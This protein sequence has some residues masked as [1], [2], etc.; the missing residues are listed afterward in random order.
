MVRVVYH[1]IWI[2]LL[3]AALWPVQPARAEVRGELALITWVRDDDA[4]WAVIRHGAAPALLRRR[5]P[6]PGALLYDAEFS[7]DGRYL[8]YYTGG[9]SAPGGELRTDLTLHVLR[10]ADGA[11]V[12]SIPLVAPDF[13][14]NIT[15]TAQALAA[16]G[17]TFSTIM[18]LDE[19]VWAA[20]V[21][22]LRRMAWSPDARHLA[23]AGS[24]DGPTSDLYL[25]T[26][27]E[28]AITRLSDG[29]EQIDRIRWSPD[30]RWVWHSTVS[31]A[32]CQ[33]CDGHQYAAAADGSTMIQ[34]PGDDVHRFMGWL[35]DA[36]F[37]ETDQANG[38]GDFDLRVVAV[39]SGAVTTLWPG[40]HE[41]FA[42]DWDAQRLVVLGHP[43][44]NWSPDVQL[45]LIDLATGEQTARNVGSLDAGEDDPLLAALA[46][47]GMPSCLVPPLVY[48]CDEALFRS[49]APDGS[50][51]V[52][53]DGSVVDRNGQR[54]WPSV[55]ALAR[56]S[57]SWR[58][59]GRGYYVLRGDTLYYRD[60]T[61][62]AVSRL[63]RGVVQILWLGR[64]YNQ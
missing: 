62:G 31:Y 3:I 26:P 41:R 28:D 21:G 4:A 39:E 47:P 58:P 25:Y 43:G 38:P 36:H 40:V 13:P 56:G 50:L 37:L 48:P 44:T 51:R 12:R 55:P 14:D 2:A 53:D 16:R 64:N 18:G 35:D 11:V 19:A 8:A 46:A 33:S 54:V 22:A 42:L 9:V 20:Y 7:P 61:T 45:Y 15:T 6:V 49:T 60:L 24:I 17:G 63:T 23:F 27:A 59:G 52:L 10:L 32:F 1:W 30:S 57:V 5:L 34:L 29:L